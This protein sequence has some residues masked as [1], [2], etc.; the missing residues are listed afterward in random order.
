MARILIVDDNHEMVKLL[1]L[2]VSLAGHEAF[3]AYDG[4]TALSL[5][6]SD[7]PDL[8]LLDLMMP[9][10]DGFETLRRLR[11]LPHATDLPVIV[12][13]AS[14]NPDLQENVASAGGNFCLHKPINLQSLEEHINL[15]LEKVN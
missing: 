10:I 8:A 6:A 15:V 4:E 14:E 3:P 11:K 1:S 12:I 5:I 7:R 13:T 9:G 2:G